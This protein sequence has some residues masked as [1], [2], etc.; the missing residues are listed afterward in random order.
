[1][2]IQRYEIDKIQG[3][4]VEMNFK[5]GDITS[6]G[7]V[8]FLRKADSKL[9]LISDV[10]SAYSD[11]R[12]SSKIT[13]SVETMLRQR[14]F[15]IALGDEDLNDHDNLRHCP[16]LQTAVGEE[17][18]MASSSTLCRFENSTNRKLAVDINKIMVEKFIQKQKIAP[19]EIVLDFD[20][21][22]DEVHGKQEG[23][24]YHGYYKQ[25]CFLPLYVF[26][27]KDLLISYLRPSNEDQAKHCWAILGLLVRRIREE[28][29]EVKI[30][31]RGDAG[32]SKHR[33]L[34]WC[35]KNNILYVVGMGQN[36]R[37]NKL[38]N[39]LMVE[40]EK[41]FEETKEKQRLFG[42]FQYKAK[43]WKH[44]KRII[45]K[46]EFNKH[47][48]NHRYVITNMNHAPQELYEEVYCMRGDME[49]RIKEQQLALFADRTSAH[50]WWANQFRLL[51]SSLAYIL[52]QYI[53]EAFLKNTLLASSQA[54]TIRLKLLK[55]GAVIVRNTRRIIFHLSSSYPHQ[56]I[57]D[58]ILSK[59]GFY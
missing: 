21:T 20:P 45:G 53:R 13:H 47:G 6:N 33:M 44:E 40:A 14:V 38:L 32:F 28:W 42:E 19:T 1:M 55:V 7:G 25:D 49:N 52:I 30:I 8:V 12:Q 50:K 18:E 57:W 31:F 2:A 56:K 36:K 26:C 17:S 54:D 37:L 16:A 58:S 29:P 41:L 43:S 9:G 24:Y 11:K 39:P 27:G 23:K 48:S 5:G 22:N 46:A 59:L 3:K 34:D 15:A 35:D 10:S 4:L 51:L